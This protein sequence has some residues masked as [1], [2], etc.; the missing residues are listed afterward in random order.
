MKI[1]CKKNK[2]VTTLV[3][4]G[5]LTIYQVGVAKQELFKDYQ[6]L[7]GDVALDLQ[8][9]TEIDTAGVQL[10]LFAKKLFSDMGKTLYISKNN[11][12]VENVLNALD[13]NQQFA[14]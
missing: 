14:R 8:Q 11:D 2:N 10:L 3:I 7:T 13:V 4:E 12:A 5:E 1:H 6:K 9:V